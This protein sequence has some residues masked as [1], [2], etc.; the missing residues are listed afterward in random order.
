[1]TAY[2]IGRIGCQVAG[3]GDWGIYNSAYKVDSSAKI[4]L[5]A[6]ADFKKSVQENTDFFLRHYD[7]LDS[8]HHADFKKPD[9]LGF[10]PNWFF[11]YN[12]PHN[13]NETGVSIP[14]CHERYCNQLPVP[15]FPTPFYETIICALLFLV[16]WAVRK[17]VQPA[18]GLFCL[19]LILNGLERFFIE[20]IR[21]NNRLDLLG[22]HPT[23]AEV[24]SAGLV[25]TGIVLWILLLKKYRTN[26]QRL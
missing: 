12:Y 18:G 14:G 16:L 15:V 17:K 2:A 11:A 22:F 10:L 26:T 6:P 7:N 13:V 23:Q 1:M 5:A 19:Y 20:K 3:D 21:V 25:F 9:A 24:I 8:I 4:V